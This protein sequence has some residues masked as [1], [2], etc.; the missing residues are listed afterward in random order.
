[1]QKLSY[2]LLA[3][4]CCFS[5]M[6]KAQ[7]DEVKGNRTAGH[8]G[9]RNY[10]IDHDYAYIVGHKCADH[11]HAEMS[12]EKLVDGALMLLAGDCYTEQEHRLTY[13]YD[14]EVVAA[15]GDGN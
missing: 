10:G 11:E 8:L 4:A 6:A 12:A 2:W 1:M 5:L 15:S 14:K 9:I 3:I 13:I 7:T